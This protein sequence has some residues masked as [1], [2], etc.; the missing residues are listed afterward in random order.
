MNKKEWVYGI[1]PVFESV[2]SGRVSCIY[3][4]K[5]RQRDLQKILSMAESQ[6]IALRLEEEEFFEQKFGKGHQGIAATVK[7]KNIL[8]IDELL[9]IPFNLKENP[10]FLILDEIEDPRNF[11]AILRVADAAGVHGVIFPTHRSA[12]ISTTVSK[13]SAGAIEFVNMAQVVNIKHAIGKMKRMDITIFGAE[14]GSE[15][16]PWQMDMRVPLAIVIGS[17]ARGIRKTVKMTCDFILSLPLKGMVNSLNVSVATGIFAYEV[18]RQRTG[19]KVMS[20]K[21]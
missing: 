2:R 17:E 1:N 3:I 12:P 11:G 21:S 20:Q 15:L 4:S 13:A 6:G 18:L 5:K 9:E 16:T 19:L 8:T 10:F 7:S 14:A